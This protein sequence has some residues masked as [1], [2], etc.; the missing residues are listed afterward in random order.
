VTEREALE[1]M[2]TQYAYWSDSAGGYTTGGLSALEDAFAVLG[3]TDP[4]PA[5]ESR[6]DEPDCMRYA[7]CGWP[8]RP[9]GT[10]PNGGYRQTCGEHMRAI[11]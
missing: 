2:V 10:G 11:A 9:G 4:M 8:T 7:S 5:P 1:G 6:C 3:W